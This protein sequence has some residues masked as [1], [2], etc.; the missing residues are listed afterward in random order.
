MTVPALDTEVAW[1]RRQVARYTYKPG[2]NLVV[3]D[4]DTG[5]VCLAVYYLAPDSYDPDRTIKIARV[6]AVPPYIT[7][8][9]DPE[10][11]GLWLSHVLVDAEVH[12]S[13][14]WLRR[15]GKILNDPH[16]KD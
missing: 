14:E 16:R 10:A 6:E 13:R 7:R 1:L 11:F 5:L 12:E 4:C 9:R 2:W 8:L 15:D 3:D